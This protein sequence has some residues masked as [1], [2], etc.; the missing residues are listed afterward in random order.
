MR[1]LRHRLQKIAECSALCSA[2]RN[3]S[4]KLPSAPSYVL[5]ARKAYQTKIAE[6]SVL[7][8]ACK[9]RFQ[10]LP[11]DPSYALPSRFQKTAE[12]SVLCA[13][14]RDVCKKKS[15][16]PRHMCCLQERLTKKLSSAPSFALPAQNA[17][18]K[19]AERSVLCAAH[20]NAYKQN[21]PRSVLGAA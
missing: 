12:L 18:Q 15:S 9:T 17:F 11:G 10:K 1:M 3:A 8:A 2:C 16:Q 21:E 6:R 20:R 19:I 5:S 4:N 13:G 7:C 14:S